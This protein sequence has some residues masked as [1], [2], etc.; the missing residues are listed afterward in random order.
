M[1]DTNQG[2]AVQRPDP[3]S[4]PEQ[5]AALARQIRI[6][7]A[8]IRQRGIDGLDDDEYNR[9]PTEAHVTTQFA[10]LYC[11]RTGIVLEGRRAQIRKLLEDSLAVYAERGNGRYSAVL[12]RLLLEPS[13][14]KRPWKVLEDFQNDHG[15]TKNS[16]QFESLWLT[17]RNGYAKFLV[18]FMIETVRRR[19]TRRPSVIDE[20]PPRETFAAEL[21]KLRKEAGDPPHWMMA[22][23]SGMSRKTLMAVE[24]GDE[25]TWRAVEA[26]V[27]ACGAD[28]TEWRHRWEEMK[29]QQGQQ[30][31]RLVMEMTNDHIDRERRR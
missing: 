10:R 29:R 20:T 25:T 26:Y 9:Q 7:L 27:R 30:F 16:P 18:G 11:E 28:P 21:R 1:D 6:E 31:A 4:D 23:R 2:T 24:R 12:T 3:L 17:V 13:L 14:T 22:R 8:R 15:L 5:L 19:G